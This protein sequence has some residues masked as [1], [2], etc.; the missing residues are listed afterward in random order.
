MEISFVAQQL[1]NENS[2]KTPQTFV[3][4]VLG[5]LL[6]SLYKRKVGYMVL[7]L[8]SPYMYVNLAWSFFSTLD[9]ILS[10]RDFKIYTGLVSRVISDSILGQIKNCQIATWPRKEK[11]EDLHWLIIFLFSLP[12]ALQ[13]YPW[14]RITG[15]NKMLYRQRCIY[16]DLI[17]G[18]RAN[19]EKRINV[20]FRIDIYFVCLQLAGM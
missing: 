14:R 9:Y 10:T 4:G 11:N 16:I 3:L 1:T 20:F 17:A 7:N 18:S 6:Y 5:P 13:L 2:K 15:Y 19:C 8:L 12:L